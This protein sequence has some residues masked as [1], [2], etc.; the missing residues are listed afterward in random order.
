MTLRSNIGM[1][2]AV[3]VVL[4][5]FAFAIAFNDLYS[6]PASASSLTATSHSSDV[7]DETIFIHVVNSTSGKAIPGEPVTAGPASSATDIFST[8]DGQTTINECVHGGSSNGTTT[9]SMN[10]APC[11]LKNY[12]T[13]ATGWV[14][15]SNQNATYFFIEAGTWTSLGPVPNAQVI[16]IAGS[17]TYVTAPFPEGN[18][19]VS[20]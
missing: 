6:P 13:N 1:M 5:A 14:T 3:A 10:H 7:V 9:I 19:T 16:A 12:D 17:Q 15:I 18:F 20:R 2:V 8:I 11:P 4:T